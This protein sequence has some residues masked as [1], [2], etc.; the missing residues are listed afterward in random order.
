MTNSTKAKKTYVL[1]ITGSIGCGKSLVGKQLQEMGVA[2]ID[3]DH[4]SH[5][6]VNNPGPAYDQILARFGADLVSS[7]G[8]PIDRKK[9]GAI[10]FND[11]SARAELEAILHP[12]IAE[13]QSTRVAALAKTHEIVAVLVPLLFETGSQNKYSAVWAVIVHKEIQ[14]SRLKLRDNLSDEEVVRRIKAQWPQAKKAELADQV[15][16]NSGNPEQTLVQVAKLVGEIRAKMAASTST[17]APATETDAPI[18]V[19]V[20]VPAP[21]PDAPVVDA[22]APAPAETDTTAPADT[23]APADTDAPAPADTDPTPVDASA[24]A[25]TTAADAA[26]ERNHT[27]LKQLGA[28]AADEALE[29]LGD[30]GTTSHREATASLTM[31]VKAAPGATADQDK[32]GSTDDKATAK[33]EQER[34]LQVDVRMSVRNKPGTPDPVPVPVPVPVPGPTPTPTPTPGSGDSNDKSKSHFTL[35]VCFLALLAFLAFLAMWFH[36]GNDKPVVVNVAPTPVVVNVP[37]PAVVNTPTAPANNV[38]VTV[39]VKPGNGNGC[40]TCGIDLTAPI[41]SPIILTPPVVTP[42]VVSEPLVKPPVDTVV[43]GNCGDGSVQILSDPP[44]FALGYLHNQVRWQVTKWVITTDGAAHCRNTI[45]EGF[46]VNGKLMVKQFY[47]PQLAYRG[48]LVVQYLNDG[49]TQVDRFNE[50]NQSV[51]RS[52]YTADSSGRLLVARQFDGSQRPLFT[53][54]VQRAADGSIVSVSY[55]AFDSTSGRSVENNYFETLGQFRDFLSTH[56]Y[57]ADKLSSRS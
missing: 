35:A 25:D 36:Q 22:D 13:L 31:V 18:V 3:A 19:P 48:Q 11:A 51:G 20:P 21:E 10:V 28:I 45:V 49:T 2:V 6:L 56:F 39:I 23:S 37:T 14:I 52:I 30:T 57:L 46:N 24:P 54:N 47:G 15:V 29:K 43:R 53:V 17:D 42:P 32:G 40:N 1:G 7:P 50:F 38:N 4:L 9:L 55:R 33:G 26:S 34:E 8:G 16:D 5:E 41:V 12:A 27:A 44:A